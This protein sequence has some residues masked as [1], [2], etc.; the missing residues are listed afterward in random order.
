MFPVSLLSRSPVHC[1]GEQVGHA[2]DAMAGCR[3][4][5]LAYVVVSEGGVAGLGET[6][7]RLPWTDAWFEEEEVRSG[8]SAKD[9]ARLQVLPKDQWPGR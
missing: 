7:R 3:S 9:F 4:G 1:G 2:I 5:R 6:L 8:L